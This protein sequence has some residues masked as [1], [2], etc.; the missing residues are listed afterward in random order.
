MQTYLSIPRNLNLD[1]G[2]YM[3]RNIAR[4]HL[5]ASFED[6]L[7]FLHD[8]SI[9]DLMDIFCVA[10]TVEQAE[11]PNYLAE[12]RPFSK[13][14][15]ENVQSRLRTQAASK[16]SLDI[17]PHNQVRNIQILVPLLVACF[18]IT[19]NRGKHTTAPAHEERPAQG[20]RCHVVQLLAR[21]NME[22]SLN[23]R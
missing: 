20:K 15:E 14:A 7:N 17:Q 21:N 12:E 9:S 19:V 22:H 11:Q 3:L 1:L 16:P 18:N 8:G 6:V 2:K 10:G 5:A 4:S 13:H 23:V